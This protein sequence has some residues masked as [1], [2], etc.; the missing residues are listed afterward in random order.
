MAAKKD[1][2]LVVV[3]SP[4]KAR[5][6][7]GFLPSTYR[8]AASNG[9]IRDLPESASQIPADQRSKEW[10]RLGVNVNDGFQPLYVVSAAKRN[11]V[12][13]LKGL[14]KDASELIVATD[15]DREGESIGWHLLQ[16]LNPRVPVSRIVFHEITEEA[17]LD[18]LK[19]RRQVDENLVRAQETRR[20]LDR[21]V[22]Y[23]VS[24]LLWKKIATGLSAGRVQSV[25]VRLLVQRE[26][27]RR[28]FR[29][30]TYWDLKAQLRRQDGDTAEERTGFSAQLVSVGGTRVAMGRD[31]DEKTGQ[32]FAGR[33]VR[34]LDEETARQLQDRLHSAAWTVLET[35][36]KPTVRRPAA[37][38]TTSTLQQEANRKL[39]MSARD[40]MRV[41]QRLYEEGFITY[42]RTDSVHLSQQA[43]NAARDRIRRSYGD[44]FLSP[45]PRQFTTQS[46]GAQEAHEAIRPAG[47]EMKTVD[48]LG[49]RG[50]ERA[51][52]EMIWKRT[53]ASQMADA[54]VTQISAQIGVEDATFRASGKRID[55]PGFFRAYVEG[56]D[57]PEAALE[58]RD[59]PLPPL[60][61]G[62]PL[63]A[64]SLDAISHA[65]QPPARF[66]EASL[67]KTL[68]SEGIGRP[69]TYAAIIGTVIDRGYV[70]RQG[71]QL[72]P[73]FTAFAVTGL[74]E[75]HFPSLVDTKF[76]AR[77]E[78]QLDEIAE[79]SAAWLPYLEQFFL[80]PE[81][82]ESQVSRGQTEI[83]PREASTV[84]LEGLSAAVRIGKF[85]PFVETKEGEQTLTASLPE[86]VAP[87][88]LS[89]EDVDRL[90][91]T[92][93]EGGTLLGT[94]PAT[95][96]PVLLM[97]GRFGPYVQL[98]E[99]SDA[100]PK[101]RRSSLPK[102]VEAGS[103]TL[104]EA[105]KLLALPR[106]LGKH[107][108]TGEDILAGIG[109]Y[110][111]YVV[112][113]K[114]F[115]SLGA[116]DDVHQVD[117]A[118]ALQLFAQPKKGGGGAQVLRELGAHPEDGEPIRLY[119]GR[120]GPY[121]KHGGVNA[122]LPK[123]ADPDAVS[124]AEAVELLEARKASGKPSRRSGGRGGKSKTATAKKTTSP[125]KRSTAAKKSTATGK[126]T[127]SKSTKRAASGASGNKRSE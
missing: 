27:E 14:L 28:A 101:P 89:P 75:Q 18:A 23:T 6:L 104:E 113:Q 77:M 42:M 86:G 100:E 26:R 11:V 103:L 70:D 69:S 84:R 4:T 47:T 40:T 71:N 55:F 20:I 37:P 57:D 68:E 22:G 52:Y 31:F 65:T 64:T 92:K 54:R 83:D 126:K 96:L 9:H 1:A 60:R 91:Q 8:I 58:D 97:V 99:V 87:A 114:D 122:S 50:Q 117:L 93:A 116:D 124:V 36:E 5:T 115:R 74:L 72:V 21:L 123:G 53:V 51:L 98:G 16:V 29:S 45:G 48:E 121:V 95:T 110:G 46:R 106:T 32:L 94:D 79:G 35:E 10:A 108:D 82:L 127:A 81:G 49:L 19:T 76:T 119:E 66:T 102:G 25:A 15:E 111:P 107:P 125:R 112:H 13:D 7:R 43:V 33:E 88:D 118:R 85:G 90:V 44:S 24:P 120:F 73:T 39:K 34:L 80:G 17:I 62:D 63:R 59:E 105:L 78:Q 38:F 2:P 61:K 67:V 56:S 30:G 3:E 41:A 12:K 109:R